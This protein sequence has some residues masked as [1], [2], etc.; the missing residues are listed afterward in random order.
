MGSVSVP[1]V[2]DERLLKF[3]IDETLMNFEKFELGE[4]AQ[5]TVSLGGFT[6]RVDIREAS[7]HKDILEELRNNKNAASSI[8]SITIESTS[9]SGSLIRYTR[10][11]D[12]FIDQLEVTNGNS[13]KVEER[14]SNVFRH[15][16]SLLLQGVETTFDNINESSLQI[17]SAHHEVLTRLEGMSA[18]LI[19]KQ[20][21][22]VQELERDKQKFLDERAEDFAEKVNS[23]DEVFSKK[24]ADLDEQYRRRNQELDERQQKIDDADNTSTRRKTTTRTLD[25]AQIKARGFSFSENVNR[26]S[27]KASQ[28]AMALVIVGAL[29]LLLSLYEFWSISFVANTSQEALTPSDQLT[30]FLYFRIL[31]SSALLVSSIVYLIRWYNSWAD[32]I[33]QQELDNQMFI[34]DLNRAQL[35][36]E[37]S[38][39]WNEK[40]D[41]EIPPR[42]LES[43]TE[44]LFKPKDSPNKELLHPAEQIAA[45]LIRTSDKVTLPFAGG[46]VETSGKKLGH[47]KPIVPD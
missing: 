33:A 27:K 47:A 1:R 2:S 21:K 11:T 35:A 26:N 37:M 17:A 25:E 43:L 36:V 28:F 40:K 10:A 30:Y 39:E 31:A 12:N 20:V 6:L 13:R 7:I 23:Q 5:C 45:A 42:L 41:G 9:L 16:N 4:S 18:E 44:G 46:T 19:E 38:L 15:L 14:A 24:V 3:F 8:T 34:R 29:G 32:R 22:Q